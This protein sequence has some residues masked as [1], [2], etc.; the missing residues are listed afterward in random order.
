MSGSFRNYSVMPSVTTTQIY[1]LVSVHALRE[2]WGG[3]HPRAQ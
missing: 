1:T 2:V 3:A